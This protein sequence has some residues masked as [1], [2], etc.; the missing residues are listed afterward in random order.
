MFELDL[1]T[2]TTPRLRHTL[3]SSTRAH[4]LVSNLGLRVERWFVETGDQDE[5]RAV[6]GAAFAPL[7]PA[8]QKVI[9]AAL[10]S[11]LLARSAPL[12]E[13]DL[14]RVEDAWRQVEASLFPDHTEELPAHLDM[15]FQA[16]LVPPPGVLPP[17]P[18]APAKPAPKAPPAKAAPPPA[19]PA[20]PPPAPAAPAA[21]EP[22]APAPAKAPPK[23]AP[24][25]KASAP[26]APAP[27]AT[28]IPLPP[29]P[30]AAAPSGALDL[31][32][33]RAMF[34]RAF[35]PDGAPIQDASL[36]VLNVTAPG[37]PGDPVRV[38]MQLLS[39]EGGQVRDI[40]EQDCFLG[41]LSRLPDAARMSAFVEGWRQAVEATF[42]KGGRAVAERN[43]PI[44]LF[45]IDALNLKKATTAEDFK[46][47]LLARSRMG[48][49]TE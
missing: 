30:A 25:K 34:Q 38:T 24:P 21:P 23:K 36:S 13:E 3:P 22:P 2:P 39:F 5:G 41:P 20:P 47:A 48:K 37:D 1:S 15:L 17:R 35:P 31:E 42:Q 33:L 27:A 8:Q 32:T 16:I 18:Q 45:H 29:I 26:A 11:P 44:N 40:K 9:A 49:L 6:Y 46:E 28:P 43:M 12:T 7:D 14:P 4:T 10:A 19:P